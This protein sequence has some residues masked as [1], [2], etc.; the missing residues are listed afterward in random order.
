MIV[1][2][3]RVH[4]PRLLVYSGI[5]AC[6]L[7]ALVGVAWLANAS[8]WSTYEAKTTI[9]AHR[10]LHQT[11]T[12]EHLESDTCT[13]NRIHLPEHGYL[14]NTLDSMAAAFEL[15]ADVV[16]LDIHPTTDGQF[17]VFHD[18]TI[19]CRTNGKGVTRKQSMAYLKTL[20]IGYGYSA[21]GG[22]T[23]PFR[24]KFVGAM[25]TLDE[26]F[27]RFPDKRFLINIKSRDPE[28]GRQLAKRLKQ[29]PTE[30]QARL[31]SYGGDEPENT[32]SSEMPNMKTMGKKRLME[33]MTRY[34]AYGWIGIV[35]QACHNTLILI[36]E[37]YATLLWGWPNRFVERMHLAGSEVYL[38]GPYGS[39]SH[40]PAGID[41]VEQLKAVPKSFAGGIWTDRIDLVATHRRMMSTD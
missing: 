19:D 3:K 24:G 29:L 22:A 6:A 23:Y 16:E 2:I 14:E 13:A 10:G 34:V 12:R 5:V 33:C 17:A 30:H 25:P 21:D 32:L 4:M 39:K 8:W 35:P 9:L 41:T 28:E 36:P 26:V 31:M 40:F 37:N 18:W 20:D 15:G 7:S 27:E 38:R 11:Y 1:T